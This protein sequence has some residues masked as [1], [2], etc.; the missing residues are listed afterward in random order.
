MFNEVNDT[1]NKFLKN[2]VIKTLLENDFFMYGRFLREVIV[3]NLDIKNLQNYTIHFF[4]DI[5]LKKTIETALKNW[6]IR[7]D[8]DSRNSRENSNLNIKYKGYIFGDEIFTLYVIYIIDFD[9][10]ELSKYRKIFNVVVD[11]DSICLC[12]NKMFVLP[13]YNYSSVSLLEVL[14][15]INSKNFNVLSGVLNVN[16]YDYIKYLVKSGYKNLDNMTKNCLCEKECFICY[17]NE[18][19]DYVILKSCKHIF[20]RNCIQKAVDILIDE[21][22]EIFFNCPYCRY[23]YFIYELL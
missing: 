12:E 9:K 1:K 6:I 23:K 16:D 14:S 15:K 17:D 19:L 21:N 11:I 4:G 22:S 3:S 20:H 7:I 10:V 18:D 8:N 13:S 5:K 2:N